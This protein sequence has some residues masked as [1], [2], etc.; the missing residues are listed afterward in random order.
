VDQAAGDHQE[1]AGHDLNGL[2]TALTELDR[3][4]SRE[5]VDDRV[6]T[7]VMVPAAD[8][9][10]LRRGDPCPQTGL[11]ERLLPADLGRALDLHQLAG[12]DPHG[13]PLPGQ[14]TTSFR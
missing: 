3:Q 2:P 7:A 13:L 9:A 8:E 10:G 5:D 12:A 6:V 4:T 14:V 1:V 11:G